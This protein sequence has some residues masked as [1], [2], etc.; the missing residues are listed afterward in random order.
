MSK[1]TSGPWFVE[2]DGIN[3]TLKNDRGD[4]VME[5]G[6]NFQVTPTNSWDWHLMSAAPE[7]VEALVMV[8]NASMK[9]NKQAKEYAHGY[10]LLVLAK[11]RGVFDETQ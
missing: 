6:F 7:L 9:S 2:D 8:M 3:R 10:A 4:I 1:Y 11:A 5:E